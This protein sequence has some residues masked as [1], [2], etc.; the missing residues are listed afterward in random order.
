VIVDLTGP[1]GTGEQ[2]ESYESQR[3]VVVLAIHRDVLADHEAHVSLI[4][5]RMTGIIGA[6]TANP[7]QPD[8]PVEVSDLG[9]LRNVGQRRTGRGDGKVMNHDAERCDASGDGSRPRVGVRVALS[10][11][12]RRQAGTKGQALRRSE[13]LAS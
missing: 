3:R 9:W 12:Q 8:E 4:A 13:K 6:R 5:Q 7:V 1:N 10:A 11:E 2:I